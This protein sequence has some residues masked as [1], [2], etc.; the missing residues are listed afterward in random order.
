MLAVRSQEFFKVNETLRAHV[1][2]LN[3]QHFRSQR[4]EQDSFNFFIQAG[5]P[6]GAKLKFLKEAV[7][8]F[9]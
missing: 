9:E 7:H 1:P 8:E 6:I 4:M 3:T 2:D 5:D